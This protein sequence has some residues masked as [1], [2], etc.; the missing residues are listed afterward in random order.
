MDNARHRRFDRQ[1]AII[2]GQCHR[3]MRRAV[4]GAI[5]RQDLVSSGIEAGDLDGILIRF[6][7][8]QREE[9]FLQIAGRDLGQFL[10]Q[11]AAR[12]GGHARARQRS[13]CAA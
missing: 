10:A 7:T 11:Q 13:T 8:A 1:T 2:A 12:L 9:G 6:R 4:I 5:A 3:A